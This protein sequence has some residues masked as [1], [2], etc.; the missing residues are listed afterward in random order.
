MC[1]RLLQ[2]D[3]YGTLWLGILLQSSEVLGVFILERCLIGLDE[4][5]DDFFS[6][7]IGKYLNLN[8]L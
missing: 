5:E 8:L 1:I 7:N 6:L 3:V 4:D 2:N